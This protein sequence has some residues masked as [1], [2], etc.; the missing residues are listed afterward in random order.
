MRNLIV[1]PAF[2]EEDS[3]ARTV[4]SLDRLPA[5]YE[6]LVVDDGST[7]GTGA[8]ARR[9]TSRLPVHVLHLPVNSGIGVAV[10]SGYRFALAR[11][12]Y[13]YVIQFDADGQ[14][15]A[16]AV[17][18]LVERCERDGLDLCIGSRFLDPAGAG[19][20]STAAR[21]VGIRFFAALIGA[22]SGVR[23]TDPTSG[24]R[25]AGPRAWRRFAEH[26]PEDYPEP[27]S[28]F[29]CA[30]NKLRVGELPVTMSERAGGVSSIRRLGTVY[31]MTK[32]TM[33]IVFDRLRGTELV[34]A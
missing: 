32:V 18:P 7:D 11:G 14:H 26:Y 29:W 21:R 17:V 9:L 3:L 20:R 25:C 30:R 10:Q 33:A 28:L 13:D 24:L 6:V 23:V 16:A 12:G 1:M 8:V 34:V 4:A 31:Y 19:F 27:E 15:D 2:N 5:G 22:L